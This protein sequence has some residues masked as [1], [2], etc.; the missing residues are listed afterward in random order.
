MQADALGHYYDSLPDFPYC[1]D[2]LQSGLVIRDRER[3]SKKRYIQHN[4]P[5]EMFWLVYD[6][7][8]PTANY[9]WQDLHAPTPTIT[10]TN[11]DS[12]RAHLFY[13]LENPV[14]RCDYNPKVHKSPIRYAASVDV[15]MI[16]KLEADRAYS[17]LISK[18]PLNTHWIIQ[19]WR[20]ELYELGELADYVDLQ[21]YRDKRVHLPPI[22]LGRNSTIFEVLRKWA[23]REIRIGGFLSMELFVD[24]CIRYAEGINR[25]FAST[26]PYREVRSIGKSIGR[27]VYKKMDYDGF[28]KWCR[29]RAQAG[30]AKSQE[31]RK[32]M[33]E[34]R[35]ARII[36]YKGLF[37][38]ITQKEISSI[39]NIDTKT[40][41]RIQELKGTWKHSL[42]TSNTG[43]TSDI[44]KCPPVETLNNKPNNTLTSDIGKCL[45][46]GLVLELPELK[47]PDLGTI[48]PWFNKDG[49]A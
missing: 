5:F 28:I 21:P 22:G 48:Y 26:L 16:N 4:D 7:D 40:V 19:V 30:N 34:E 46:N 44:G 29:F 2:D 20:D 11:P 31:V 43:L 41:K 13:G 42:N 15:G 38:E 27:W 10:A 49:A 32:K 39:F 33:A 12:G 37:H 8:R 36:E 1:T 14:I 24:R 47:L 3:A 6:I 25:T 18:N 9:D 35:N 23:Y 17:G 45:Q